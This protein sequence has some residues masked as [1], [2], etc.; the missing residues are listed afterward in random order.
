MTLMPEPT[1]RLVELIIEGNNR[2]LNI[3][4]RGPLDHTQLDTLRETILDLSSSGRNRIQIDLAD[5]PALDPP[6]AELFATLKTTLQQRNGDLTFYN[7][8]P[9]VERVLRERKLH[10]ETTEPA[11]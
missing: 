5:T 9:P 10:P 2:L 8:Q 1:E 6:V 11:P 4:I 3:R 7:L